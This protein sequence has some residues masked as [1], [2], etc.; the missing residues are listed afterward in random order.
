MVRLDLEVNLVVHNSSETVH[1][2]V[3]MGMAVVQVVM[4]VA[5]IVVVVRKVAVMV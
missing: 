3:E 1:V 5:L 4:E 2:K